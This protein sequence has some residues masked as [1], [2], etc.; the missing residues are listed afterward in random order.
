[1]AKVVNIYSFLNGVKCIYSFLN[2][3]EFF[4][5]DISNLKSILEKIDI[6]NFKMVKDDFRRSI[7]ELIKDLFERDTAF[8]QTEFTDQC[9]YCDFKALC[10]R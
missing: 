7:T 8:T 1:M 4:K 3:N 9:S 5:P 2:L 10:G 6:N